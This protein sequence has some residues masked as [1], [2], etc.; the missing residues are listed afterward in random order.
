MSRSWRLLRRAAVLAV[1]LL[2][3]LAPMTSASTLYTGPQVSLDH[4]EV[5][6]GGRVV[7]TI[8]GF[9]APNVTISVCGDEARRGSVDCNMFASEGLK[10]DTDGTPTV[11][12]IPIAVPPVGCPCVIRVADRTNDEIAIAPIT[13]LGHAVEPL[14]DPPQPGA[15]IDVTVSAR[16]HSSGWFEAVRASAG[17]PAPYEVTVTVTNRSTAPFTAVAVSGS[18]ARGGDQL[19]TLTLDDPGRL[20]PG[21]TW[22][23]VVTAEVPG[24]SF[25][26]LAWSVAVS[27]AGATTSATATTQE[28]P[29]LLI[30]LALFLVA[31]VFLLIIRF[32]VR[33]RARR[34]AASADAAGADVPGDDVPGDESVE[35]E[36]VAASR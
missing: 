13:I 25:G 19:A 8:D 6:P 16:P 18:V 28:R 35:R 22:Q 2:G 20:G 11:I 26:A 31:D 7:L 21:R 1:L 32:V 12:E 29:V 3:V 5:E 17:G 23:Q 33:R 10:L 30:A 36:L 4:E 24:P 15:G 34:A 14:I 27:G 9:R